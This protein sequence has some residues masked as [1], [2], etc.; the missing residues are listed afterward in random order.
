MEGNMMDK[1]KIIT[2]VGA[3]PQFIKAGVVSKAF[4][5]NERF[6]EIIL[7]TG[8]HYDNYMSD[9]F[10]KELGLLEPKYNLGVGSNTHGKQT[11]H[12]LEGIEGVLLYEKPHALVVYGDTNSTIAGALAASKL[13]IPVIHIEAGVRSFNRMMPEEQNR[14][15]TD[16][17][18]SLLFC[19]TEKAVNNLVREGITVDVFN[20]GD[21]MYDST[22]INRDIA[23][24]K[25]SFDECMDK[26]VVISGKHSIKEREYYLAT[27]HRAENTDDAK[28]VITILKGLDNLDFPVILLMHPRT[29]ILIKNTTKMKSFR[30]IVFCMPVSYLQMIT[31][32]SFA[33]KIITDSGGLQ[34]EAYFLEVPCIT[35]RNETEWTETIEG[36]WNI[37]CAVDDKEI[38]KK[39]IEVSTSHKVPGENRFGDGRASE[40]IVEIVS[41]FV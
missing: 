3:R 30:N 40:K 14:V 36:N 2:V 33:K 28:K 26:L 12:M 13:H 41:E 4:R 9:V 15:L 23:M 34:K 37:L 19:P 1:P 31:L 8:Q 5:D 10:F 6:E 16:H 7:H 25:M 17:L 11:A 20:V 32:V 27:I 29:H 18:S 22:L 24:S 38:V 35:I 21:V 39:T